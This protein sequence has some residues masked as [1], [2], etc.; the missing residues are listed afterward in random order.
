MNKGYTCSDLESC[1]TPVKNPDNVLDLIN[2]IEISEIQD[3]VAQTS[4]KFKCQLHLKCKLIPCTFL[5]I[6]SV[7]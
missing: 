1:E 4:I 5:V 6:F 7:N 3:W 2:M